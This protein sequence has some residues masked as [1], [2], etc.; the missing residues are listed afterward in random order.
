[1]R[2]HNALNCVLRYICQL[3]P[4]DAPCQHL[5]HDPIHAAD[6]HPR[7]HAV[8]QRFIKCHVI[9]KVLVG[10]VLR[11]RPAA[12]L[13]LSSLKILMICLA[14]SLIAYKLVFEICQQRFEKWANE[15]HLS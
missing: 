13:A 12:M 14:Y 3:I 5:C 10:N 11:E 8:T 1:M 6:T 15:M 9:D 4:I 7:S 2:C